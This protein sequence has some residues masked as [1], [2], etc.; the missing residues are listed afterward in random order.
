MVQKDDTRQ[1]LLDCAKAEFLEYGYQ[2]ASLRRICKNAGVTTGALYFFFKDKE[3]LFDT[4]VRDFAK[5]IKD[6]LREHIEQEEKIYSDTFDNEIT[7]DIDFGKDLISTYYAQQDLGHLLIHCSQGTTYENY[8]DEI[9]QYIEHHIKMI[10]HKLLGDH[11]VFNECTMHWLSHL[12]V[13]AFLHVLS[14]DFSEEKAMEQIGIV[15]TFLR[16]GFSSLMEEAVKKE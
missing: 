9:I 11:P 14:H 15:V 2:K 13:E 1:T 8:F 10:I 6:K 3:D 5:E 12:Q 4:L 16:G 7:F